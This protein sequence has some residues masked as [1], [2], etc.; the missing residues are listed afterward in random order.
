MND[1]DAA[2]AEA[3]RDHYLTILAAADRLAE[4]VDA[5]ERVLK[6]TN[7][8]RPLRSAVLAAVLEVREY[9]RIR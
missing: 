8:S 3:T 6:S 7:T 1:P 5:I 2:A 9:R 4:A